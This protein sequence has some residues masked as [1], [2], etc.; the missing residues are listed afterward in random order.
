MSISSVSRLD[1]SK[2]KWLKVVSDP[3]GW[4]Y[5]SERIQE[6]SRSVDYNRVI[7]YNGVTV[8]P[9]GF[10]TNRA[11]MIKVADQMGLIQKGKLTHL[12]EILDC[13][14]YEENGW[15]HRMCRILWWQPEVSNWQNL[16]PQRDLL[17]FNP[18]LGDGKPHAIENLRRFLERWRDNGGIENFR[19]HL[20]SHL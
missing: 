4:A 1:L 13:Q 20:T 15:H 8:F 6:M 5:D 11:E 16:R 10:R 3:T 18:T 7:N 2:L 19:D 14:S 17:G 12:I 9:L